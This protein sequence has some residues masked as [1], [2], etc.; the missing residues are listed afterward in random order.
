MVLQASGD[1]R[2]TI[3]AGGCSEICDVT[4]AALPERFERPESNADDTT[5]AARLS[6]PRVGAD[7]MG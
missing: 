3:D 1:L 7:Q 2:L 6:R 5:D 4:R